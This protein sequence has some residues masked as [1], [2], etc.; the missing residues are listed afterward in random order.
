MFF[1][2]LSSLELGLLVFAVIFAATG[3]GVLLG[4]RH[5]HRSDTLREPFG[6]LQGAL[7]GVVGLLL[8]FGL[9]LAVDRYEGRRQ[10]VV[11]EAN[12]INTTY[13]RAQFLGDPARTQSLRL[14][15]R[16]ADGAILLT[17]TVPGSNAEDAVE[18]QQLQL[19]RRLWALAGRA[20]RQA[21]VASAPRLYVETLNE[22]FDAQDA[23]VAGLDNR[24]PTP[25]LLLEVLGSAAALALLSFYLSILGRGL[26]TVAMAAVLVTLLLLVTFDLDRPA[27]GLISVPS[28][29]LASVRASMNQPPAAGP[30]VGPVPSQ[31]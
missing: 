22:M 2:R 12:A 29:A 5:R 20:L 16:Y 19:E 31:N 9:A 13:L 15:V 7:L 28:G 17:R 14:L 4:W 23:R 10:D 30:A 8:A 6:A 27:R 21:P 1:F 11:T 25:V 24:V 18:R 26:L 3:A